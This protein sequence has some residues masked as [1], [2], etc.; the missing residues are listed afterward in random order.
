MLKSNRCHLRWLTKEQLIAH[1][2]EGTE[3]GGYFI[4]KGYEKVKHFFREIL[5]QLVASCIVSKGSEK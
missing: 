1:G 5:F 3:K 4:C 2:E